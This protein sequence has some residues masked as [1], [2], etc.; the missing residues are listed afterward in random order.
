M[1]ESSTI[2]IIWRIVIETI[3]KTTKVVIETIEKRCASDEDDNNWRNIFNNV[4]LSI[5]AK[6][7]KTIINE[8][9]TNRWNFDSNWDF[10]SDWR[11]NLNVNARNF[12]NIDESRDAKTLSLFI[13]WARDLRS[14]LT[15][16]LRE[17][18]KTFVSRLSRKFVMF[19][20]KVNRWTIA[21]CREI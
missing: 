12:L 17:K 18:A 19:K 3:T 16:S 5:E 6:T 15:I 9:I 2:S 4:A 21:K 11:S 20:K 7:I 10:D 14:R 1:F 13:F 8:L